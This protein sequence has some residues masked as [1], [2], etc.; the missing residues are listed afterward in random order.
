MRRQVV[1][2][3]KST[4]KSGGLLHVAI[5]L[6]LIASSLFLPEVGSLARGIWALV[7]LPAIGDSTF[8]V[9]L[10]WDVLVVAGVLFF[11]MKAMKL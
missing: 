1:R 3:K 8:T 5:P 9:S 6:I 7:G 2:H 10:S 4:R 11:G